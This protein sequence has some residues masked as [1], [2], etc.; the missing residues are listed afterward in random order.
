MLLIIFRYNI[1]R[2][3]DNIV[4]LLFGKVY[5]SPPLLRERPVF[6]GS[7]GRC[8]STL[9]QAIL[10]TNPDFLIWGEHNGFL[11]QVSA[12]YFQAAHPRFPDRKRP[13]ETERIENL[14]DA[15]RWPAWDNLCG[16]AGFRERF[17]T[18][19]RSFFAD[20]AGQAS[21]WG[22]KEIRYHRDSEDRTFH[23]LFECF[24]EARL[25]VLVR[26]P[27]ATILSMLSRWAFSE[28]QP[29][30]LNFDVLDQQI[31]ALA[32]SWNAQ[33]AGLQLFAQEHAARCIHVRYEDLQ[34]PETYV[35]LADF[36]QTSSFS[37]QKK[38]RTVK[39]A[40]DKTGRAA[41]RIQQRIQD[42]QPQIDSLTSE[43][44]AIHGYTSPGD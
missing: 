42:L 11:R 30:E 39:D 10:N 27:R 26:E 14:R 44:R 38:I 22:F 17:Q 35:R 15:R 5:D 21:R 29:A 20:P 8:G 1:P 36:L 33:Y 40:A 7:S 13:G 32:R 43:M 18:F 31:L 9:L 19:V 16:E 2:T 12:S 37:F 23:F 25:I 4:T 28:Q 24:P 41:V 34:S 3:F 6:I